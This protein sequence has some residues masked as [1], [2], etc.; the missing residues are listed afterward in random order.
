MR[1]RGLSWILGCFAIVAA[2]A[3]TTKAPPAQSGNASPPDAPA[4]G[5]VPPVPTSLGSATKPGTSAD[6]IDPDVPAGT[7]AARDAVLAAQAQPFVD[8]FVDDAPRLTPDGK[9]LV[10]RS[11]RDGLPQLYVVD[12]AKPDAA[13]KRL[14]T[15]E[16]RVALSEISADGKWVYFRSDLKG[17]ENWRIFRVSIDGGAPQPI[18][19]DE[20][21]NR[22]DPAFPRS[23]PGKMIYTARLSTEKGTRVLVQSAEPGS[24][25]KVAHVEEAP[26][27]LFDVSP[28]GKRAVME[29]VFSSADQ[30]L[31]VVDL[32]T[33]ATRVLPLGNVPK[34]PTYLGDAAFSPDAKRVFVATDGGGEQALVLALDAETGKE[35]QRF[36][37][38]PDAEKRVPRIMGVKAAPTGDRL[39]VLVDLG[40]HVEVRILDAKS[41]KAGAKVALPLGSIPATFNSSRAFDFSSDGQRAV[42]AWDTPTNPGELLSIELATGKTRVLHGEAHPTL[43]AMPTLETTIVDV[44]TFDGAKVSANVYLPA[45]AAKDSKKRPVIVL[46]HGG[47]ASSS[48]VRWNPRVT[49][50][51]ARGFAVVEPNVRGSTGFGR[52]WLEADDYR[53]RMD[54]VSDLEAVGKWTIAQP[55]ADPARLVLMGQSYGGYMTL[56][57]LTHQP[58]LWKAGVELYGIYDWRAALKVTSGVIHHVFQKEIGPDDDQAFLAEISPSSAIDHAVAP[59]FVYAGQNDPRVPRSESDAIV[60]AFRERK[61]P[62]E[63]LVAMDEGHS[64]DRTANVVTFLA[65]SMRFLETSLKIAP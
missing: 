48:W 18:A 64:L 56:M 24:K 31:I 4:L 6:P 61:I 37:I 1:I 62:V 41:L 33:D 55:W 29:R 19:F 3:S 43:K 50:W 28:D 40:S 38:A 11:N 2:C 17:D 60:R 65:R 35:L 15:T 14:V 22:F 34:G 30:A 23:A 26:A 9:R 13:P 36:A 7:A 12:V 52:K 5:P 59:L 27:W 10:F 45:G 53:K 20:P 25:A 21:L 58:S 8:A 57:G 16:D 46:V 39:L 63:Y 32:E 42:I 44:T 47:R 54:A 51:I 49:F